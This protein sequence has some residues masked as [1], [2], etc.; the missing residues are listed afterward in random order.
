M[1]YLI[2][3]VIVICIAIWLIKKIG[4]FTLK[5]GK[6]LF[7]FIFGII[8]IVTTGPIVL[9]TE[10]FYGLAK[11][12]HIQSFIFLYLSLPLAIHI[13]MG[14]TARGLTACRLRT[15]CYALLLQKYIF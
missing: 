5:I 3:G 7:G 9:C 2:V 14:C 15:S 4:G 1:L 11:L 8:K 10:I 13:T 12:F 6:G